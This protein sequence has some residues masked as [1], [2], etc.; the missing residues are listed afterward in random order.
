M[1]ARVCLL[2]GKSLSRI[3]SGS[4]E[5]FCSREHRNQYRLRRGMDRLHEA[6]KVA[7]VMRRR[8]IPRPIH[9]SRLIRSGPESPRD[10]SE[11]KPFQ[12]PAAAEFSVP[13]SG[14][15]SRVHVPG[16]GALRPCPTT[17]VSRPKTYGV[18]AFPVRAQIDLSQIV[19]PAL[20]HGSMPLA[21]PPV[22]YDLAILR[23]A[24]PLASGFEI[25]G[26]ST[27]P[28]IQRIRRLSTPPSRVTIL[29]QGR[30]ARP[31]HLAHEG[32]D[33]RVSMTAAFRVSGPSSPAPHIQGP[34]S[35]GTA[36]LPPLDGSDVSAGSYVRP[37]LGTLKVRFQSI[38][39][40]QPALRIPPVP[41]PENHGGFRWPGMMELPRVSINPSAH[42]RATVV[43][44]SDENPTKERFDEYR[45]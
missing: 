19:R 12:T 4:A 11:T 31:L 2:C 9:P 13:L 5:D 21:A 24:A 25:G 20:S 36:W 34:D 30:P 38:D 45:N 23:P 15:A 35:P 8:E 27:F 43:L 37:R 40:N 6:N 10:F 7:S 33:L 18:R 32:R 39:L 17:T 1:S 22:G 14:L 26:A 44:F 41:A 42:H 16:R 28:V 29:D 3:W